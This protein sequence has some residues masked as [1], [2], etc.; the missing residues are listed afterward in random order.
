MDLP[1]AFN[2]SKVFKLPRQNSFLGTFKEF[3]GH[4]K[5]ICSAIFPATLAVILEFVAK[6]SYFLSRF[7]VLVEMFQVAFQCHRHAPYLMR[8]KGVLRSNWDHL[9]LVIQT[10]WHI[11]HAH[12]VHCSARIQECAFSPSSHTYLWT[13]CCWKDIS[14]V[15]L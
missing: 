3:P 15:G 8:A 9:I 11:I 6:S 5:A 14:P 4:S 12:S 13:Q 7:H 10:C 2:T 1:S